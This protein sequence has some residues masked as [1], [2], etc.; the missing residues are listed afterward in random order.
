[1][2]C[3]THRDL[4]PLGGRLSQAAKGRSKWTRDSYVQSPGRA[5]Q[6]S[7]PATIQPSPTTCAGIPP[8]ALDH[9][10]LELHRAIVAKMRSDPQAYPR[11]LAKLPR[12]LS[13]DDPRGMLFR[14][15]W[16]KVVERGMDAIE[17]LAL[18]PSERGQVMRSCSPLS[19][20]LTERE[21]QEF[22]RNWS[23][24]Q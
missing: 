21:R 1:M 22:L 19:G 17:E 10:S 20:V 12:Y 2:P 6:L 14:K 13:F 15:R 7:R 11:V 24:P 5:A 8:E 16:A 4:A 9:K 18:D 23:P 3:G